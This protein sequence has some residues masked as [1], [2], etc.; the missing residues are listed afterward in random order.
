MLH[1]A[2]SLILIAILLVPVYASSI[3][4][5]NDWENPVS[6]TSLV[7]D[8]IDLK[9][10][11]TPS[12]EFSVQNL[13]PRISRYSCITELSVMCLSVFILGLVAT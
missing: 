2:A 1:K 8:K 10:N 4:A 11:L 12:C 3:V 9:F 6:G 7:L 13:L 5:E